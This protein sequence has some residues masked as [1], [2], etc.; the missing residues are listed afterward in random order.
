[1]RR[2]YMIAK[3]AISG[4]MDVR[5]ES[6]MEWAARFDWARTITARGFIAT[7]IHQGLSR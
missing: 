7:V 2:K 3:T 1:M 6:C 4:T 5:K